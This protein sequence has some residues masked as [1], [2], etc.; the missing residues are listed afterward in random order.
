MSEKRNTWQKQIIYSVLKE[1]KTHPTVQNL[2]DELERR[3]YTIGRSTVYRVMAD[4]V[5]EGIVSNVYSCDKLE[6][7]DGDTSN[8]YH[9]RCNVCKK[10]F[11]SHMPY[12]DELIRLGADNDKDFV[13]L[14]HNLEFTGL[15][16]E[17]KNVV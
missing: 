16:P 15:C 17:C 6:H 7:Y 5:D 11:D 1:L 14:S 2:C 12:S 8:H 3:G 9:I 13:I 4:A 10:I